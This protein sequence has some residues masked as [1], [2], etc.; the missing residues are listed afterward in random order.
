[1]LNFETGDFYGI[2]SVGTE[3]FSMLKESHDFGA[4]VKKIQSGYDVLEGTLRTD[5]VAL[6]NELQK[7]GLVEKNHG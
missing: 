4:I 1:M 3:V 7:N 6:F 2:G 5:L